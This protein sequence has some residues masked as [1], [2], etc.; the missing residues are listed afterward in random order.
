MQNWKQRAEAI[1]EV[2]FEDCRRPHAYADYLEAEDVVYVFYCPP[3]KDLARGTLKMEE[4]TKRLAELAIPQLGYGEYPQRGPKEG[5]SCVAL[6]TAS[7]QQ[8]PLIKQI[9]T[10]V[11]GTNFRR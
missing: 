4:L 2:E 9:C 10:E 5:Y 7:K 11:F 8:L 6:Y 3:K 1:A